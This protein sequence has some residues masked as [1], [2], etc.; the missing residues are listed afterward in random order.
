MAEQ[1]LE[2]ASIQMASMPMHGII[3]HPVTVPNMQLQLHFC[4]AAIVNL[5]CMRQTVAGPFIATACGAC[6]HSE[7]RRSSSYTQQLW[8]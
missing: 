7:A 6:P 1:S 2:T 3:M 4:D 8:T 5:S